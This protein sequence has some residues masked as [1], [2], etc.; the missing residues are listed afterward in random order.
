MYVYM[1]NVIYELLYIYIY[2]YRERERERERERLFC[3]CYFIVFVCVGGERR[4]TK[5]SSP[6]RLPKDN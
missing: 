1:L 5:I 4:G 6:E 2:I 3:V